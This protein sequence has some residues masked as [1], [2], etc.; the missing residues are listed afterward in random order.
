MSAEQFAESDRQRPAEAQA[1]P[2]LP[3]TSAD[4]LAILDEQ[5]RLLMVNERFAA[6]WERQ[7]TELEGRTLETLRAEAGG[8]PIWQG[9]LSELMEALRQGRPQVLQTSVPAGAAAPSWLAISLIPTAAGSPGRAR[10]VLRPCA[11]ADGAAGGSPAGDQAR[12]LS[13]IAHELRAP[14]NRINGF[15]DLVLDA[16]PSAEEGLTRS[17]LQ[18]ARAG[19]EEL[20][21]LLENLLCLMR[22]ERGLLSLT[23]QNLRLQ[24]IAEAATEELEYTAR[25]RQVEIVIEVSRAL[26]PVWADGLRLRHLLRNLLVNALQ[27]AGAGEQV[28]LRARAL[29]PSAAE[30]RRALIISIEDRGVGIAPEHLS[31]VFERFYRVQPGEESAGGAGRGLGLGLSVASLLAR[32]HGGAIGLRSAAG[33]GTTALLILP[34]ANEKGIL[35]SP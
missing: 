29:S 14:L 19:S 34:T 1:A 15:L 12:L 2:L 22:A 4:G 23:C 33:Q 16:G 26:P 18:R 30:S 25:L 31:H 24:E 8:A 11:D 13:R 21:L 20:Y 3:E 28:T 32:L 7:A 9:V 5:A 17:Y 6:L 35:S 27:A 10:L